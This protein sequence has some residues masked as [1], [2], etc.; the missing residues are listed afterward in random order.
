MDQNGKIAVG[1]GAVALAVVAV[2]VMSKKGSATT[3]GQLMG[4]VIDAYTGDPI[5]GVSISLDGKG[6]TTVNDG[7]FTIDDIVPGDYTLIFS[8]SGYE[9]VTR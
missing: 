4:S 8:K 1:V 6:T 2:L 5:S 9:T 3:S 7:S